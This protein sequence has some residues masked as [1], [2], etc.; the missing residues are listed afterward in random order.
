MIAN[1]SSGHLGIPASFKPYFANSV[2]RVVLMDFPESEFPVQGGGR[3]VVN[4]GFHGEYGAVIGVEDEGHQ[5]TPD[6]QPEEL[7][8]YHQALYM[9]GLLPGNYFYH[10]CQFPVFQVPKKVIGTVN[11]ASYGSFQRREIR[12]TQQFGLY[13]IGSLKDF[14]DIFSYLGLVVLQFLYHFPSFL[15]WVIVY[16]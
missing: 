5:V 1:P 3:P 7:R 2:V 11:K 13:R 16:K 4:T 6:P 8:N 9:R 15:S 14:P 12:R 10:P